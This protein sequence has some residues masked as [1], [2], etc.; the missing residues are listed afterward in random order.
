MSTEK[1]LRLGLPNTFARLTASFGVR[2]KD[3]P[4]L[5][6][7]DGQWLTASGG[8][9]PRPV[10]VR[11]DRSEDGRFVVTGLLLGLRDRREITWDTL[12]RLNLA[13]LLQ[14]IF[15]DYDPDNPAALYAEGDVNRGQVLLRLWE[16]RLE[17]QPS[18]DVAVTPRRRTA[19]PDLSA[20]ADTYLRNLAAKPHT[21]MTATARELH[22]S[23]ATATRRAEEC[24]K[25]GLLP[26]KGS[27]S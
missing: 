22:I 25:A 18:E 27:R 10:A 4:E 15:T 16:N 5:V 26:Q 9:L 23:R 21:A 13:S 7:L 24:R 2:D 14:S 11:I 17:L 3:L 6:G 20:F 19:A 8:P 1:P 12:R